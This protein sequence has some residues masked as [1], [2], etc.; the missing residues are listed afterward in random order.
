[1]KSIL[2]FSL[3]LLFTVFCIAQ[4]DTEY[5]E[6]GG[7]TKTK[8]Y[9]QENVTKKGTAIGGYIGLFGKGGEVNGVTTLFSGGRLGVI[10]SHSLALGVTGTGIYS[11]QEYPALGDDVIL[12]GGYGGVFIEPIISPEKVIHISFPISF[13]A[14]AVGYVDLHNHNHTFEDPHDN[15]N[16]REV[17]WVTEPGVNLEA[18]IA[19]WFRVA[20]EATYRI[21][22]DYRLEELH[23]DNLNGFSA[24]L[25]LKFGYF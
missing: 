2:L 12:T 9:H 7:K 21:S 3:S 24:G 16:F 15:F 25:V 14:G 6:I 4:D 11:P 10:V 1:M 13:N 17:V 23:E 19:N 8:K 18:N 22:T 5:I 20:A